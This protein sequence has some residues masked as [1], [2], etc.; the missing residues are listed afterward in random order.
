M[1]EISPRNSQLIF[2][3]NYP[4]EI[5]ALPLIKSEVLGAAQQSG[6]SGDN[7]GHLELVLEEGAVNIIKHAYPENSGEIVVTLIAVE[8][9]LIL[10]L[11]DFGIPFDPASISVSGLDAATEDRPMGGLGIH[12][13]KSIAD[14][15]EYRRENDRNTLD[16]LLKSRC[17]DS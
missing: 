17:K 13:M 4:A 5:A 6:W 10:R 15:I 2:N 3:R 7:L 8:G 12:L 1:K 16:I 14:G 11:Q 9:G